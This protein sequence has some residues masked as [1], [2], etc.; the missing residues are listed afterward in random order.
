MSIF[1]DRYFDE[2]QQADDYRAHKAK[3]AEDKEKADKERE[4]RRY[5]EDRL[6]FPGGQHGKS[7]K[8]S[9]HQKDLDRSSRARDIV[10]RDSTRRIHNAQD[11]ISNHDREQYSKDWRSYERAYD[12]E[13]SSKDAANRHIRRHPNQYK[14]SCSIF[15]SVRFI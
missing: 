8:W 13:H 10:H 4:D 11:S 3:E 12:N 6:K 1:A 5:G 14:E 9:D 15:E 2:G 7:W